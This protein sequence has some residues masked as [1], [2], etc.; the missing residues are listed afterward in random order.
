M[1][2]GRSR[3]YRRIRPV[4]NVVD[5]KRIEVP[6]FAHVAETLAAELPQIRERHEA[7]NVPWY[8]RAAELAE[9][10]Q[11]LADKCMPVGTVPTQA[12][13]IKP[14][15]TKL[16][17]LKTTVDAW[18]VATAAA[19]ERVV[20]FQAQTAT[21]AA[22]SDRIRA[23]GL[24]AFLDIRG[25]GPAADPLRG[26]SAPA[27]RYLTEPPELYQ[28]TF[29]GKKLSPM[30][31]DVLQFWDTSDPTHAASFG[32]DTPLERANRELN[33][34]RLRLARHE[35]E[36]N[37]EAAIL[38]SFTRGMEILTIAA[39]AHNFQAAC[40]TSFGRTRTGDAAAR[41]QDPPL[42]AIRDAAGNIVQGPGDAFVAE[43]VKQVGEKW[44]G[45]HISARAVE[46]ACD[47]V[48]YGNRALPAASGEEEELALIRSMYT[49]SNLRNQL[50]KIRP[51]LAQGVSGPH[52]YPL[53]KM[54]TNVLAYFLECIEQAMLAEEAHGSFKAWRLLFILKKGR[55]RF[56]LKGG[57]R[58]I[59]AL[60]HLLANDE[61][62]LQPLVT[63]HVNAARC[64]NNNGYKAGVTLTQS[65]HY[66]REAHEQA[67]HFTEQSIAYWGDMVSFF[68]EISHDLLAILAPRVN[69]PAAVTRRLQQNSDNATFHTS[70][71]HGVVVGSTP[72][73]G[74][75]Q[76][77]ACSCPESMLPLELILE[78]NA[79][80]VPGEPHRGR[81]GNLTSTAL[82][83]ACDDA[84]ATR[85]GTHAHH[86]SELLAASALVAGPIIT[87]LANGYAMGKTSTH[88]AR[89]GPSGALESVPAADAMGISLPSLDGEGWFQLEHT[90]NDQTLLGVR[91]APTLNHE[92]TDVKRRK[93]QAGLQKVALNS[94]GSFKS[95]ALVMTR[96]IATSGPG[97]HNR[98]T[99]ASPETATKLF[100]QLRAGFAARGYAHE[101][102]CDAQ[103]VL[104]PDC[105]PCLGLPYDQ[106]I[107]PA[108]LFDDVMRCLAALPRSPQSLS[109]QAMFARYAFM[110]GYEP[111]PDCPSA[112]EYIPAVIDRGLACRY[113]VEEVWRVMR[114]ARVQLHR[115]QAEADGALGHDCTGFATPARLASPFLRDLDD[116]RPTPRQ[117]A[118]LRSSNAAARLCVDYVQAGLK[119]PPGREHDRWVCMLKHF[120]EGVR[121]YGAEDGSPNEGTVAMAA[122]SGGGGL[123]T[124]H[125]L[126]RPL[127]DRRQHCRPHPRALHVHHQRPS[128]L[129]GPSGGPTHQ[130]QRTG[131]Y[132]LESR[133][134]GCP[135]PRRRHVRRRRRRHRRRCPPP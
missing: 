56:D 71:P 99:I 33:A 34:C 15:K 102:C 128:P 133:R 67:D 122:A 94:S 129:M 112:L 41:G 135:H 91:F 113:I 103:L 115:T 119:P 100:K 85:T 64:D 60:S 69:I 48:D 9:R 83:K 52:L 72:R 10:A 134:D 114:A 110:R 80:V 84:S 107:A 82:V 53:A 13:A 109:I 46:Y 25:C 81:D 16:Q 32:A 117:T 61:R 14:K 66:H 97:Y 105:G 29:V 93:S 55:D 130:R 43:I 131:P 54:E 88:A 116:A 90:D 106:A 38:S 12:A 123:L 125:Q 104:P 26:W 18:T 49:L 22:Y 4:T 28:R 75:G 6:A 127:L 5:G 77:R 124:C 59:V 23:R 65:C 98:A 40:W 108:A 42:S 86:H 76:G 68:D 50:R 11:E 78:F 20:A 47:L 2:T 51:N 37:T 21:V 79:A 7:N 3:D 89:P 132:C 73:K 62:M 39:T 35:L 27:K 19:R 96:T 31:K 118:A 101:S 17:W 1:S 120:G 87:G 95:Q 30:A 24:D 45:K 57:C 58:P 36:L 74:V 121:T 8:D 70:T 63:R 126:P 92:M 111:T 44:N